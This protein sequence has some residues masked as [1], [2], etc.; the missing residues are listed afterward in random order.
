[1]SSINDF[2]TSLLDVRT[3]LNR[4]FFAG[5]ETE[6]ATAGSDRRL[7]CDVIE[8]RSSVNSS[9]DTLPTTD[10]GGDS[11][12][13]ERYAECYE[14]FELRVGELTDE[15]CGL[16][17]C[18]ETRDQTLAH[19]LRTK[20]SRRA[21]AED[22]AERE[23]MNA[24]AEVHDGLDRN[25]NRWTDVRKR[26]LGRLDRLKESLLPPERG[27]SDDDE[28][29]EAAVAKQVAKNV[30]S[31]ATMRQRRAKLDGDLAAVRRLRDR[32]DWGQMEIR[33]FEKTVAESVD[34]YEKRRLAH[35]PSSAKAEEAYET[36]CTPLEGQ[37]C[38][39]R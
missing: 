37:P 22:H 23:L 25:T 12:A 1:M 15:I 4:G 8:T 6:P 17:E 30:R 11:Y 3:S 28:C 10:R 24:L 18:A 16:L 34:A 33:K 19:V 31:A 38:G 36:T 20:V 35:D 9:T 21:A 14:Y 26:I 39:S 32:V 2:F 13:E 29:D 5:G 27:T 7:D